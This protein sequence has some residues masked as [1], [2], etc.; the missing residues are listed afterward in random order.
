MKQP[1]LAGEACDLGIVAFYDLHPI[2]PFVEFPHWRGAY[3]RRSC[4]L[5]RAVQPDGYQSPVVLIEHFGKPERLDD[6]VPPGLVVSGQDTYRQARSLVRD[7][8]I[9]SL[10]FRHSVAPV[11]VA[12]RK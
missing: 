9:G 1:D 10:D 8:L 6:E 2:F 7:K 11:G 4:R 12:A 5:G 3:A